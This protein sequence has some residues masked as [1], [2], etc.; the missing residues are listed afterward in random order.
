MQMKPTIFLMGIGLDGPDWDRDFF[1]ED[2]PPDWRLSYYA[3]EYGGILLPAEVWGQEQEPEDWLDD[4]PKVFEF[5]FQ[6]R[7]GMSQASLDRLIQAAD[8]LGARLKGLILEAEDEHGYDGLLDS[9]KEILP[10]RELSVMSPCRDLSLCWQPELT[11]ET[12]C[13]PGLLMLN[14]DKTPRELRTVIEDFAALTTKEPAILFVR[15]P[16]PVMENL[17]TLLDLMGY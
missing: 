7:V 4:V 3:N 6:V 12:A 14:G 1:P 17:K 10:G 5:H 13:G 2:L 11:T 8:T 16:V 9:L 15:A